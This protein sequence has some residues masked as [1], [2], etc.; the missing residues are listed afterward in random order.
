MKD[1]VYAAKK[2]AKY[3]DENQNIIFKNGSYYLQHIDKIY[4]DLYLKKEIF[5]NII[6]EYIYYNYYFFYDYK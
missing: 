2:G 1:E 3:R 5:R 4:S 6:S